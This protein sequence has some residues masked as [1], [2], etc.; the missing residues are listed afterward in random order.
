MAPILSDVK[1]KESGTARVLGSGMSGAVVRFLG[2]CIADRSNFFLFAGVA[3]LI[4]FHPVDTIAKRLM[5]NKSKVRRE[6]INFF[7][8]HLPITHSS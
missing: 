7:N 5:S 6:L 4:V 2:F 3:E 8:Y 1:S